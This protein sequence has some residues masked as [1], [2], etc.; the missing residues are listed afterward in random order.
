MRMIIELMKQAV[1]ASRAHMTCRVCG[2]Q[3]DNLP[4]GEDG[5]TPS[6]DICACCGVTHGYED[7]LVAAVLRYRKIWISGGSKWFAPRFRPASWNLAQQLAM[8]PSGWL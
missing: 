3:D 8:I 4:Y 2:Y 5:K 1:R 6:F 7:T